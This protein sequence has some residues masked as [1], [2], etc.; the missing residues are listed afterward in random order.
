MEAVT[1]GEVEVGASAQRRALEP[2]ESATSGVTRYPTPLPIPFWKRC[3]DLALVAMAMPVALPVLAISALWVSLTSPGPVFFVQERVGRGGRRF[4]CFKLRTMHQGCAT[5]THQG[6]LQ[7]LLQDD[8]PMQKLDG[9]DPRL[10]FGARIIR[11]LGIDELPQ[12]WNVI[13]GEMSVIGPRPCIPY[14]ADQYAP[15]HRERFRVQPGMTGLWQVRGKNRTT[16]TQMINL[17]IDYVRELSLSKDLLIVM[18]TPGA[19]LRQLA[20]TLAGR[21]SAARREDYRPSLSN[22]PTVPMS[23]AG[24]SGVVG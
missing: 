8:R 7:R 19:V 2:R 4:R 24:E 23:T 21:R 15:W 17:D 9:A 16:F 12:L 10:V 11:A 18:A 22:Q 3:L 14:E 1:L 5:A 13:R 6:H 20:C